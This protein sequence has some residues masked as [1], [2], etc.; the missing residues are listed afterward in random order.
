MGLPNL[1]GFPGLPNFSITD[2]LGLVATIGTVQNI[3]TTLRNTI[4]SILASLTNSNTQQLALPDLSSAEAAL[5]PL[6]QTVFGIGASVTPN[7]TA[8]AT[9]GTDPL[10][11]RIPS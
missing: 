1:P 5:A 2:I 3:V 9:G 6:L 8:I 11:V 10:A 7:A 4:T